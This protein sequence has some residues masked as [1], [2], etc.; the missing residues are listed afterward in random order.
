MLWLIVLKIQGHL[1]FLDS[2]SNLLV[3]FNVGIIA[4]E[5]SQGVVSDETIGE[6]YNR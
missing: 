4:C 5:L 1:S 3:E 6:G 2:K